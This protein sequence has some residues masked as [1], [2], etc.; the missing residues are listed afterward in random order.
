MRRL[1]MENKEAENKHKP[2]LVSHDVKETSDYVFSPITPGNRIGDSGQLLLAKYKG[3]RKQQYLVKHAYCDCAANEFVY[4]KLAQAM[5]IK[6]P[7]AVLF[8]L[9]DGEKRRYFIT[10]YV[11]GTEYINIKDAVPS[12]ETIREE[13]INWQDFFRYCALSDIFLECDSFEVLLAYDGFIYRV[14]TS[15]AFHVSDL[16]LA[17]AGINAEV[18]GVIPMESMKKRFLSFNYSDHQKVSNISRSLESL[19]KQYG[20]EC[21]QPYLEP[22]SRIQEIPDDYIDSFLDTLCYFYPDFIGDYYRM[23]IAAVQRM[24]VEFL[25]TINKG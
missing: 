1:R 10:E 17:Q 19:T 14:D 20:G 22:F 24:S 12:Y 25:C 9:S 15:S 7:D 16:F 13:A 11:L 4:T 21:V 2:P 5:D 6:M 3:D 23:F 8:R 18:N